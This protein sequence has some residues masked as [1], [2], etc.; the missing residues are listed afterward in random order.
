MLNLT[1]L[2][3]LVK[4]FLKPDSQ[5]FF[6]GILRTFGSL[7]IISLWSCLI[8]PVLIVCLQTIRFGLFDAANSADDNSK[9]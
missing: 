7:S 2:S 8:I 6:S 4:L 1:L 5:N 3:M 9:I